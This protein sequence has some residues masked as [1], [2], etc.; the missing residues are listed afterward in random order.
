MGSMG[1]IMEIDSL[2]TPE[3]NFRIALE[4]LLN[5]YSRENKSNTPDFILAEYLVNCLW[6]FDTAS[7]RRSRWYGLTMRVKQKQPHKGC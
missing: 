1:V 3:Q 5:T 6:A 2:G 4:K 7:N